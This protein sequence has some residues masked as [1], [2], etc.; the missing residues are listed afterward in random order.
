MI[1]G[2]ADMELG[3]VARRYKAYFASR[4]FRDIRLEAERLR[5]AKGY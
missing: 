5:E 2:V 1:K 4:R 3:S